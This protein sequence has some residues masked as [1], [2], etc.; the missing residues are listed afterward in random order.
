M[1]VPEVTE[2]ILCRNSMELLGGMS[3]FRLKRVS[4]ILISYIEGGMKMRRERYKRGISVFSFLMITLWI[5]AIVILPNNAVAAPEKVRLSMMGSGMGTG[6]YM[7]CAVLVD[8][9]KRNIP[10]VDITLM[11]SA[12]TTANYLPMHRGEIDLAAAST[13]S[14]YWAQN[15]MYF[16]K[17]KLT[18]FCSLMPASRSITHVFTYANSPI[19]TWK[20]MDGKKIGLGARASATSMSHEEMFQVLGIKPI[21]VYSTATEA[22][23]LMKDKRVD[24]MAYNTGAPWSPIMD[25]ATA[26]PLKFISIT[27]EEAE[28]IA[29]ALPYLTPDTISA[30]T[31][32]FQTEDI[33]TVAAYQNIN[34]KPT[35][36]E[37]LVYKLTKAIWEHWDEVTKASSAAKW[38]K[39]QD[40]LNMYAPI[41]PGAVKY[42]KEIGIKIPDRLIWKAK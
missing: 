6:I 41:H 14:D 3:D 40:I 31:Y 33:Y 10:D 15:G 1:C 20:D 23:D 25:I 37:E 13:P 38:I 8:V 36:P 18:N 7:F 12:G 21:Y 27:S 35:L 30:K 2:N 29:K 26:Q 17:E 11:I 5:L 32:S 28:K 42:Y 34:V 16:T 22:V 39:P 4:L 9:W 24:G 19:K